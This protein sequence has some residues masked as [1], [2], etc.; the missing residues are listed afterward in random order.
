VADLFNKAFIKKVGA[1]VLKSSVDRAD[2][3]ALEIH[4]GLVLETP[5]DLGQA[6]A[7]WNFTL[8]TIDPSI[9][10]RPAK[11]AARLK[12]PATKLPSPSASKAGD[13]YNI[14][15]SVEHIIYLNEGSS[16]QAAK[17]FVESVVNDVVSKFK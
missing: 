6:R 13:S 2:K 10:K 17:N 9:P 11:G 3:I 1:Q 12:S 5:V 8:N 16:E 15:N 4:K 7:G 14:S